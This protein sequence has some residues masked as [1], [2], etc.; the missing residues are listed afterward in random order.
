[1]G[2]PWWMPSDSSPEERMRARF[3]WRSDYEWALAG[4]EVN[5][6]ARDVR[7]GAELGFAEGQTRRFLSWKCLAKPCRK[8][9]KYSALLKKHFKTVD[10]WADARRSLKEG[11]RPTPGWAL[12]MIGGLPQSFPEDRWFFH[13]NDT[14]SPL[15]PPHAPAGIQTP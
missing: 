9:A 3:F 11:A 7:T 2:A 4:A 1:M 8:D 6:S 15:D 10:E 14:E 12:R 5:P 13:Q